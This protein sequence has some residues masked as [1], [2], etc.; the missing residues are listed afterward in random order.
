MGTT[1]TAQSRPLVD[2]RNANERESREVLLRLNQ[3]R[4]RGGISTTSLITRIL[5]PGAV[6]E[7]P[8]TPLALRALLDEFAASCVPPIPIIELGNIGPLPPGEW[9]YIGGS[10][11]CFSAGHLRLLEDAQTI[12]KKKS[13]RLL[14]GVWDDEV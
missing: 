11:D 14:A 4:D 1:A 8:L 13:G 10:W 9:S 12:A 6:R 2:T 3:H 7:D 5:R